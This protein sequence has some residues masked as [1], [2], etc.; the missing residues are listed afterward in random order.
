MR[1][2][3]HLTRCILDISWNITDLAS[4]I[5]SPTDHLVFISNTTSEPFAAKDIDPFVPLF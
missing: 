2:P 4:I 3:Y 1:P 5:S